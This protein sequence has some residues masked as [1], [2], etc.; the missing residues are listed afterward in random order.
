MSVA[1]AA[2]VVLA[3]KKRYLILLGIN[4]MNDFVETVLFI[5]HSSLCKPD[6]EG[7]RAFESHM[8][9]FRQL[10]W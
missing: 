8:T 9:A 1:N 3:A 10:F 6:C 5:C 2:T 4:T 7:K